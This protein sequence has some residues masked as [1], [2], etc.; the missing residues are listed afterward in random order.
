[1]YKYLNP[2]AQRVMRRSNLAPIQ[3][4]GLGKVSKVV[5]H[6]NS[7]KALEILIFGLKLYFHCTK[8]LEAR[9]LQNL[10]VL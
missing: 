2:A 1:M 9:K 8:S 5:F 10:E 4:R 3:R 6:H 7:D